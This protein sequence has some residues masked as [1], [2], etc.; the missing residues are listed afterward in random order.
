MRARSSRQ[1]PAFVKTRPGSS[2]QAYAFEAAGLAWLREA[3]GG[4]PVPRVHS[5]G[6]DRLVLDC[7]DT[8]APSEPAARAFGAALARTHQAGAPAFGSLPPGQAAGFI[9]DLPLEA[10]EWEQFGPFLAGGR[11][12]P[13]AGLARDLGSLSRA[14]H[15]AVRDLCDALE[16]CDPAVVGPAEPVARL[17]GD[18]WSGNVLWRRA[19]CVL[20]DP[21]AQGGHRETDLAMLALFGLPHLDTV[22]E[23][24]DA[25]WPLSAG[26]RERIALHQVMPLLVHAVLFGGSY[27][28]AAGAAAARAL[29]V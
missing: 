20:I 27:G 23:A 29:A 13:M 1:R 26:W 18:L 9:A 3:E 16:A 24:Y 2:P 7:V 5:V 10:G 28:A 19:D 17:H 8:V 22:L 25:V 11:L 4:C 12:R 14:D 15:A 6:L 21:S